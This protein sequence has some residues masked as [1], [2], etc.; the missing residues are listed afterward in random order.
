MAYTKLFNKVLASSIWN[1]DDKTRIVWI[2]ML[3]MQNQRHI[4]EGSVGGL[5]HMARVSLPDCQKAIEILSSPDPDD[6]SKVDDGRRIRPLEHGGWL[7]VNGEVY[8]KAQDEDERRARWAAYM[9]GY[10]QRQ[11][12]ENV[13]DGVIQCDAP[14]KNVTTIEQNRIEQNRTKEIKRPAASPQFI[15][16]EMVEEHCRRKHW[17]HKL[18][19]IA[20]AK[21]MSG[22]Y[23]GT[24]IT[25]EQT[26]SDT[27]ETIYADWKP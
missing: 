12:K 10:R 25:D 20:W 26:F 24:P 3:A 13:I 19:S 2:T 15:T 11:E 17:S 23:Y 22:K 8:R 18:I 7:I 14:L 16:R 1:E 4:V 5:A 27:M 6:S 9:R 21:L